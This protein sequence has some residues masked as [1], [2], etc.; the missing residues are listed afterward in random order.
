MSPGL[1]SLPALLESNPAMT[2]SFVHL[3]LQAQFNLLDG[4]NQ[5]HETVAGNN[6]CDAR[7]FISHTRTCLHGVN[8]GPHAQLCWQR[9]RPMVGD[10]TEEA[11]CYSG[12]AP[13][14]GQSKIRVLP[15]APLLCYTFC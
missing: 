10:R 5:M 12:P 3:H 14:F 8:N 7:H 2:S 13:D 1:T 15:P 6:G 11:D 9:T 4:A